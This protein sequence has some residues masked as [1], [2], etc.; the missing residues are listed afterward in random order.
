MAESPVPLIMRPMVATD[1]DNVMHLEQVSF[2]EPW[3]RSLYER[4]LRSNRLS[5]YFV[6]VPV[7]PVDGW[8]ALLGQGGYWI[9]GEEVHIVTLAVQPTWRRTGLGKWLLLRLL[10]DA[11]QRGGEIAT[12]EVRPS[13]QAARALYHSLGFAQFS[14]RKNYYPD[15][16]DAMILELTDLHTPEIW[17]PLQ[18]TLDEYEPRMTAGFLP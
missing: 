2:P 3:P 18:Q 17:L 1:I 15:G 13:N 10:A 9:M 6:V 14:Q 4:E 16:E 11:R 8:P 12:L 7:R 5:H